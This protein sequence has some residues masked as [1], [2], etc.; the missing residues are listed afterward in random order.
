MLNLDNILTSTKSENVNEERNLKSKEDENESIKPLN[1]L[2]LN[3][4]SSEN[5]KVTL[6]Q[7]SPKIVSNDNNEKIDIIQDIE[8][9]S[10]ELKK[11]LTNLQENLEIL[12]SSIPETKVN[13]QTFLESKNYEFNVDCDNKNVIK[14][15]GKRI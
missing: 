15:N 3:F 14:S 7:N 10:F 12:L 8:P 9:N 2:I 13:N 6:P 5:L 1:D 4:T 11:E